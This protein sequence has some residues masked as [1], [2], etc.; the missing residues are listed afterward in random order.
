MNCAI[1]GDLVLLAKELE[2]ELSTRLPE[3]RPKL[4]V[5]GSVA[6][7]TRVFLANE[8]D[9]TVT[10]GGLKSGQVRD[11]RSFPDRN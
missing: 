6:E 4:T 5:V 10:F 2:K 3:L 8:L 11:S 1:L 7:G 9:L